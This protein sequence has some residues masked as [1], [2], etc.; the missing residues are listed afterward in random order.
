[1]PSVIISFV[2]AST[3]M[4]APT[5]IRLEKRDWVVDKLKPL[6]TK[7]FQTLECGAC[8][9]AIAGAKDVAWVNK[10]WVLSAGKDLCPTITKMP[11]DFVSVEEF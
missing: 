10:S 7:A 8:V 1:M 5:P 4:A 2:A 6:F 9:A 3:V 11:A